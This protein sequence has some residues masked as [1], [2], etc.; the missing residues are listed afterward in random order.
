MDTN[1]VAISQFADRCGIPRPTMSQL[2]N[3]RNK[4]ISDEV[5]NK[6][7]NAY[8][9]LSILWLMFGEGE[10]VPSANM[11]ISEAQNGQNP[12]TTAIDS[13]DLQADSA[14]QGQ[15]FPFTDSESDNSR[16]ANSLFDGS[17][18]DIF[19]SN[20]RPSASNQRPTDADPSPK[21][22]ITF[23]PDASPASLAQSL[24]RSA[25]NPAAGIN[26]P[27]GATAGATMTGANSA[28]ATLSGANSAGTNTPKGA[29]SADA[30]FANGSA[31]AK[32]ASSSVEPQVEYSSLAIAHDSHKKITNIVVF[33]SDNSFQSFLPDAAPIP[34]DR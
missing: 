24:L 31:D 25:S 7:H 30:K 13:T 3:G 6:I 23:E 33:Y 34:A 1:Q 9:D 32:F 20:Q 2:M 29:T 14:M 4:R 16:G 12:V 28:G 27:N 26:N 18:T 10:M 5:I 11:Q 8:P 22:N 15:L 17:Q 19:A 21:A